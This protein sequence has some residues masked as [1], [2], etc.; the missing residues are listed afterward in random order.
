[1]KENYPADIE[2][3]IEVFSIIGDAV[4]IQDRDY[5]VLYQND[6]HIGLV[7]THTGEYCYKAYEKKSQRCEGCPI[8][9]TFEDGGLHNAERSAPVGDSHIHVEI[10]SSPIRDSEGNIIAGVELVRDVSSR[11]HA[12]VELNR[13]FNLTP[14][15]IC[16][17]G[18]DGYF[19]RLNKAWEKVLG[20]TIEELLEKPFIGLI[21]PDDREQTLQEIEKLVSGIETYHFE[22]RFKCK[23]GSY[24]TFAWNANPVVED[25]LYAAARDITEKKNEEV[26]KIKLIDKLQKAA[27]KVKVLSGFIPICAACKQIRD[28]KGFW[29]Q[30]E[31]Y[32]SE[33]SDAVFSHGIC[34]S[35]A[36]KLYPGLGPY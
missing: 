10:T 16:V 20:Y 2:K 26:D 11:K 18:T 27:D 25:K 30:I 14:D 13:I 9:T 3:Y 24:K 12:E 17:A 19:K 7:G 31:H 4:S 22:N 35:C 36:Q 23:D 32:I 28:D 29:N 1:M 33:H 21:H 8:A 5:K 15:M 6:V 34:P